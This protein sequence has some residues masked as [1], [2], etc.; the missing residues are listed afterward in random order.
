MDSNVATNLLYKLAEEDK[1][2]LVGAYISALN[3]DGSLEDE[4]YNELEMKG[5]CDNEYYLRMSWRE[6]LDNTVKERKEM[7]NIF[8]IDALYEKLGISV[9]DNQYYATRK[10]GTRLRV[11]WHGSDAPNAQIKLDIAIEG[12]YHAR[13]K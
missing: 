5:A 2:F 10:D 13:T 3:K 6:L 8:W 11:Y 12:G 1:A 7:D 9:R 4:M